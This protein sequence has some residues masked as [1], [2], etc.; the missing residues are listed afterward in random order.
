[1]LV[2]DSSEGSDGYVWWQWTHTSFWRTPSCA[3]SQLR[4]ELQGLRDTF[5]NFT[6]ST[7]AEVKALSTQ[8]KGSGAE[9]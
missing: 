9:S 5:S 6:V 3:D 8:G 7:E 1:M 4:G 2:E